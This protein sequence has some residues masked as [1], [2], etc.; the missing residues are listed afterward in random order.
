MD[1]MLKCSR[2]ENAQIKRTFESVNHLTTNNVIP[3]R[4]NM[5]IDRFIYKK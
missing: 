2:Q 3:F 1:H 4:S 5:L